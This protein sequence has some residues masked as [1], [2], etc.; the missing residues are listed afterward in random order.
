M[1]NASDARPRFCRGSDVFGLSPG[2][3]ARSVPGGTPP[4]VHMASIALPLYALL[5][6]SLLWI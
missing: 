6:I 4:N 3:G 2:A 1:A 5:A